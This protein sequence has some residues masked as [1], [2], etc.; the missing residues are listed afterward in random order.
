MCNGKSRA[1]AEQSDDLVVAAVT[2][3]GFVTPT[4]S[5]SSAVAN[6][7]SSSLDPN[8]AKARPQASAPTETA[9]GSICGATAFFVLLGLLVHRRRQRALRTAEGFSAGTNIPTPGSGQ[10]DQV[11]DQVHTNPGTELPTIADDA[12]AL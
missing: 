10:H 9:I 5:G 1:S 6:E 2:A 12:N 8:V 4:C 11:T 7:A 3:P